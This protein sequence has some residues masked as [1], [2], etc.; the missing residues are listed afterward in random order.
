L[1]LSEYGIKGERS[2]GET[3]VW[4]DP[5]H[6]MKARKICAMGVRCSRWITMHGFALNVNTNLD[7]FTMIVP[8]GIAD[9]QVTSLQKELGKELDIDQVKKVLL[10]KFEEVFESSII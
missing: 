6:K 10:S 2:K 9:K 8:C 1:T 4:I 3:G 7:Y 5:D